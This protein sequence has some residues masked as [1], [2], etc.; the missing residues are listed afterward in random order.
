MKSK[1]KKSA[2][3]MQVKRNRE[4]KEQTC[5][6]LKSKGKKSAKGMQVKRNREKQEQTCCKLKSKGKKSA[7]GIKQSGIGKSKSKHVAS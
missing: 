3:G 1:G 5:C 2:K 6:K 7:K 4:K